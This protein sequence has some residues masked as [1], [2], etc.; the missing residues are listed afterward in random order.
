MKQK[1]IRKATNQPGIYKNLNT[2][3]YDVKHN[4]TSIDPLTGAKIYEQEWTYSINSYTEAV[5][6]LA[7]KRARLPR[8]LWKGFTLQQAFEVWKEKVHMAEPSGRFCG[9]KWPRSGASGRV[10]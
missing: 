9:R 3:K 5:N 6:L 10:L 2:G 7:L 1:T 4:Y 8:M